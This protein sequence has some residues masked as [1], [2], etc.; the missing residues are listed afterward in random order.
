M[1]PEAQRRDV[2]FVTVLLEEHPLQHLRAL[3]AIGGKKRRSLREVEQDRVGLR[4]GISGVELQERN[5][6]GGVLLQELRRA[7]FAFENIQLNPL[8]WDG[9]LRQQQAHLVAVARGQIVVQ[10]QHATSS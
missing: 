10:T 6:G 8:E 7:C 1:Q 5:A 2:R 3:E 9:E 4:E